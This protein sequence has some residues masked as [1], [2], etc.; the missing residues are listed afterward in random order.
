MQDKM[1]EWIEQCYPQNVTTG[2]AVVGPTTVAVSSAHHLFKLELQPT[3]SEAAHWPI[4]FRRAA[5]E[6]LLIGRYGRQHSRVRAYELSRC[7]AALQYEGS[8][9]V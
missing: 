6:T 3:W 5:R 1:L 4:T 9:V 2:L 8:S 7:R